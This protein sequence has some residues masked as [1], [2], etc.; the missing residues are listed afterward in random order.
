MTVK[1]ILSQKGD[2][3]ITVEPICTLAD[4]VRILSEHRIGALVIVGPDA[5]SLTGV[6]L[7]TAEVNAKRLEILQE[8][9]PGCDHLERLVS[10]EAGERLGPPSQASARDPGGA[11]PPFAAMVEDRASVVRWTT[12]RA[13]LPRTP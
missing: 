12:R 1:A 6:K 9:V 8:S 7:M 11:R 10:E 4:A 5:S 13:N 3:V 2:N